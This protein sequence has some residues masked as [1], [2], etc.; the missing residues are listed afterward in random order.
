VIVCCSAPGAIERESCRRRGDDQSE[1]IPRPRGSAAA[2]P[3]AHRPGIR[4]GGQAAGG[5]GETGPAGCTAAGGREGF[6]GGRERCTAAA[7]TG[8]LPVIRVIDGILL[9]GM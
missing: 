6:A 9:C 7:R 3:A 2:G 1:G 4:G 5:A 8:K